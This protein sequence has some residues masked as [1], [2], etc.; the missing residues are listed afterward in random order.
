MLSLTCASVSLPQQRR[1]PRVHLEADRRAADL[2]HALER[3]GH[4]PVAVALGRQARAPRV[5][6]EH[7]VL[8]VVLLDDVVALRKERARVGLQPRQLAHIVVPVVD[9]VDLVPGLVDRPRR[10]GTVR[11]QQLAQP[12]LL[13]GL[14][15]RVHR[16]PEAQH[17]RR[18]QHAL[19]IRRV[20]QRRPQ[21][22]V[23]RE[24]R[25]RVVQHRRLRGV[26]LVQP[27]KPAAARAGQLHLRVVGAVEQPLALVRQ[28]QHGPHLVAAER[29]PRHRRP[30]R[31][32][33]DVRLR[34]ASFAKAIERGVVRPL[35]LR[36]VERRTLVRR[37][38]GLRRQLAERVELRLIALRELGERGRPL[39]GLHRDRSVDLRGV[40][41]RRVDRPQRVVERLPRRL[42]IIARQRHRDLDPVPALRHHRDLVQ[43][44]RVHPVLEHID[45]RRQDRPRVLPRPNLDRVDQRH[46]A[47]QVLA[48]AQLLRRRRRRH[49]S[50]NQQRH[51]QSQLRPV[52][53]HALL[54]NSRGGLQPPVAGNAQNLSPPRPPRRPRASRPTWTT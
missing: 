26:L 10:P 31:L 50:Q 14:R 7:V 45:D 8:A 35:L 19:Q 41:P 29:V 23:R 12:L 20:V 47:A 52:L 46:A 30:R 33:P 51:H 54:N 6:A 18:P 38:V 15:P 17:A 22:L 21:R 24:L 43:V 3:V 48:E 9:L 36:L 27:L 25:E 39:P 40:H 34:R 5:P 28:P 32:V 4:P 37:R 53:L 42:H 49:Q 1:P 16:D 13:V 11:L 2:V 44:V